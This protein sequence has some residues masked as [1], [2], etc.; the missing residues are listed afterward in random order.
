MTDLLGNPDQRLVQP[1]A[2]LD[3]DHQQVQRV[4]QGVLDLL[5]ALSTLL[6]DPEHGQQVAE[7]REVRRNEEG[8][9]GR[10]QAHRDQRHSGREKTPR[11]RQPGPPVDGRRPAVAVAGLDQHLGIADGVPRPRAQP[12]TELLEDGH[13]PF[14]LEQTVPPPQPLLRVRTQGADIGQPPVHVAASCRD[15]LGNDVDGK[16]DRQC[17]A[18]NQ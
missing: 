5:L 18:R 6:P 1:Q 3:A 15:H 9:T 8:D 4:R 12:G 13:D 7:R 16:A 2:G 14:A 10:D 17:E 11:Q